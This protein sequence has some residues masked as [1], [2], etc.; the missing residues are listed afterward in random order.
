M[1]RFN[2]HDFLWIHSADDLIGEIPSW[3]YSVWNTKLPLVCRRDCSAEHNLL[4]VGI[5]GRTR[6]ERCALWV[7]AS[8]VIRSVTP[9]EVVDLLDSC[10]LKT[11]AVC[12]A[13]IFAETNWPFSWGIT[14]SCAYSLVTGIN[15]MHQTSDLDLV[16]RSAVPLERADLLPWVRVTSGCLCRTDTQV[17][18]GIGA[19][20]LNEWMRSDTVL[21]KTN[22]G[23]RL[24]QNPWKGVVGDV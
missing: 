18:T 3:V 16:I 1:G 10:P 6:K 22:Q 7:N 15:V 9:Q 19:F 4:P 12:A 5:R 20:S 8:C 11:P 13:S 23:P 14:G 17:D 2:A 24:V 21:L